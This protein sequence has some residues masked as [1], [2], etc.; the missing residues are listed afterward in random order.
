M[1]RLVVLCLITACTT[2]PRV[3][4]AGDASPSR[5]L[6]IWAGDADQTDPDFLVVLD[7]N[8]SSA[9]Y[10]QVLHTVPVGMRGSMPHHLEYELPLEGHL[11]FANAH[12]VSGRC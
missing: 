5:Y 8:P 12:H 2:A 9:G 6:Y 7:V 4:G 10:G 3:D 11:L 1:L